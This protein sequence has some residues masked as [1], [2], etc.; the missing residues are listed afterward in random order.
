MDRIPRNTYREIRIYEVSLR[1]IREWNEE[2]DYPKEPDP[3][4]EIDDKDPNLV[5]A[6]PVDA[7][8]YYIEW[9]EKEPEGMLVELIVAKISVEDS[10]WRV[11][12][13]KKT[14]EYSDYA[15]YYQNATWE[16]LA[17]S[18]HFEGHYNRSDRFID[19]ILKYQSEFFNMRAVCEKAKVNYSTFR[20]FKNNGK[21][22]SSVKIYQLLK[23]MKEIGD[24]GWLEGFDRRY[25]LS[26]ALEKRLSKI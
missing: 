19:E 24:R 23:A 5:T 25:E 4:V 10:D 11:I 7:Y 20:G 21:L 22:M 1:Q 18:G 15:D 8:N 13:N 3:I 26:T 14:L 17:F 6:D 12:A 9:E 2:Y 16:A